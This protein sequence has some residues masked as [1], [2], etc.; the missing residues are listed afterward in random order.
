M[1]W[2]V[3]LTVRKMSVAPI[4]EYVVVD[5]GLL[6][7]LG[8]QVTMALVVRPNDGSNGRCVALSDIR[9]VKEFCGIIQRK[10]KLQN[11]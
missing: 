2:V 11:S 4:D 8:S 5:D 3:A 6:H 10:V 7:L 1:V 9:P